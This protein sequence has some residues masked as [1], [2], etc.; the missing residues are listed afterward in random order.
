MIKIKRILYLIIIII[1]IFAIIKIFN[2][3]KIIMKKIY[4][5]DYSEFIYKYSKEYNVD[6]YIVFSI[7]KNESNFKKDVVSKSGAIGLMQ[8]M[9]S[10]AK[11]TATKIGI[12]NFNKDM[13]YNPEENIKIGI[14]YYSVIKEKYK[15]T[16]IALAA[17][18]AGIGTVDGWINDKI[19]N[20]D[21][22]NLEEI[23]YKET[24][25]YVRK[26]LRDYTIYKKIYDET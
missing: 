2:I 20:Y 26:I 1:L 13:L 9:E 10:T 11:E 8:L 24:N 18:N 25:I 21:G 3:Q 14:K 6:P 12:Y 4:I 19:I 5:R 17:Y 22:T 15:N 7:I 23:P 16:S